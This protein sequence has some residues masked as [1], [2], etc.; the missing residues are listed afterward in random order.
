MKKKRTF[1]KNYRCELF[2]GVLN[3][4]ILKLK[5]LG[6]LEQYHCCWCLG[7]LRRQGIS[8]YGIVCV[9]Q[10][11][12]C[13]PWRKFSYRDHFVNVPSQWETT[14]QCNVVSHWLG[15]F[16]KCSLELPVPSQCWEMIERA[17][18]F[19]ASWNIFSTKRAK[20]RCQW[21]MSQLGVESMHELLGHQ[22][23]A[24][25]G[26]TSF[27]IFWNHKAINLIKSH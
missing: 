9:K 17:N 27:S 12:P 24:A 20:L 11:C 2:Y 19:Y 10:V 16:T 3:L 18:I 23:L 14:L 21:S 15:A 25:L 22:Q 4:L 13:L 8:H 6:K 5:Y 26:H 1:W 7:S